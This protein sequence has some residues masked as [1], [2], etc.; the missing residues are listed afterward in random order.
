[1]SLLQQWKSV[2]F[3]GKSAAVVPLQII[4]DGNLQP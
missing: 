1:M 4:Y 2:C 3:K